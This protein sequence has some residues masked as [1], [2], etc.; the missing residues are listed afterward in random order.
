MDKF[1]L[2]IGEIIREGFLI[3]SAFDSVDVFTDENKLLTH[4]KIIILLYEEG[5]K[6]IQQGY[7]TEDIKNLRVIQ[8]ILRIK[9]NIENE[10]YKQIFN[11]KDQLIQEINQ[12][13][14]SSGARK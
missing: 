8:K 13:K 10:D 4:I 9:N 6:L 3:Q 14:L 12:L 7:F 11:L 1:I 5:K 2:F